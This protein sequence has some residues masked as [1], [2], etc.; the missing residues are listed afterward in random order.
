MS[1]SQDAEVTKSLCVLPEIS[2]YISTLLTLFGVEGVLD[3]FWNDTWY[4]IINII[5]YFNLQSIL[6]GKIHYLHVL[7][8]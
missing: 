2:I 1:G 4:E 5:N 3:I 7:V 8:T 6:A